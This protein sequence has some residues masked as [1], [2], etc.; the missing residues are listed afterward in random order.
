MGM[1][2]VDRRGASLRDGLGCEVWLPGDPGWDEARAA[3]NLAVDQHPVAVARPDTPEDVAQ[4]VRAAVAAGLR[5]APQSTGH[6]AAA[7]PPLDDAVLVRLDGLAD[8]A[9][10]PVNRRARVGAG[11]LW[12]AVADAAGEHGLAA[13]AGSAPDVA[14]AGYT[15]GGGLGWLARRF[16]LACSALEAVEV[17]T[18][19]GMLVRADAMTAPELF[20]ALR[21]GGGSFGVVTALEFTLHPVDALYA[22]ALMWPMERAAEVLAAWRGWT[23]G[24]PEETTSVGRLVHVPPLPELPDPIRGRDLVMVEVFH[25]GGPEEGAALVAPLR[26]LGPDIDTLAVMPPAA[27][28]HVHMDPPQPS[29]A[30][31][32]GVLLTDAPP[33]AL[34]ALARAA[35][36]APGA[37]VTSVEVRHLGGAVGR[38]APGGGALDHI[39]AP[40]ALFAVGIAPTP[41]AGAAVAAGLDALLASVAPWTAPR[42]FLNL[43]ERPTPAEALL[44]PEAA[45]RARALRE[46][47]DPDGVMLANHPVGGR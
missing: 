26:A 17:V 37:A 34:E 18:P 10:D 22:G 32:H 16:G 40:F 4:V 43:S 24:V 44:G 12:Q 38:P 33:A 5:I 15:L 46:R 11:A 29:P 9:V 2:T 39:P 20:W 25:I 3:W 19:D 35:A 7:R 42:A 31:G 30:V 45:A 23:D 28:G 47:L 21:G 8:V 14:V 27:L 1:T 6:G 41:P 13:L 36:V